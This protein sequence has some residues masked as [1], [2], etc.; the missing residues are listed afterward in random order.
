MNDKKVLIVGLDSAPAEIVFDRKAGKQR[1][2][3]EL[4]EGVPRFLEAQPPVWAADSKAVCFGD[5]VQRD[6]VHVREVSVWSPA[7]G[8]DPRV[9]AE[10]AW[11]GGAA[12]AGLIVQRGPSATPFRQLLSSYAPPASVLPRTESVLLVDP[13][14]RRSGVSGRASTGTS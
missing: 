4:G 1:L 10:S 6:R 8:D 5:V 14:G 12:S 11:C 7:G 2:R 3:Y 9:V 13:A